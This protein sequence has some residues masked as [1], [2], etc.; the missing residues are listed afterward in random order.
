MKHYPHYIIDLS[1][2]LR[3]R[4]TE[5]EQLLWEH[6]RNRK[7]G[8]LKFRRQH[9]FGRYISDFYCAELFLIIELEGGIHD[10]KN[11]REYDAYRE[12]VLESRGLT[13]LK[14]KNEE[15]L[16]NLQSVLSTILLFKN[17]FKNP[18]PGTGEGQG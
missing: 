6:L 10:E 1:R 5:A 14:F 2:Q 16:T 4:A 11:Q 13:V 18:S 15:V 12:E 7:L 3:Q 17:H 8:G 9:H